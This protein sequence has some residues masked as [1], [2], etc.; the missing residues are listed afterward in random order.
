MIR[1]ANKTYSDIIEDEY[2]A[3]RGDLSV[4]IGGSRKLL[5]SLLYKL[6]YYKFGKLRT[7]EGM[8]SYFIPYSHHI[9]FIHIIEHS[10]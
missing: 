4:G 5:N 2:L 9:A 7:L 1:I 3:S 10:S 8:E 6:S